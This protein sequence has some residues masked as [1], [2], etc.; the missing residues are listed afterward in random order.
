MSEPKHISQILLSIASDSSDSFGALLRQCPFIQAELIRR[1]VIK[2]QDLN[3]DQQDKLMD[4]VFTQEWMS[5]SEALT[6][7]RIGKNAIW[8][9]ASDGYIQFTKIDGKTFFRKQDLDKVI[10]STHHILEACRNSCL[11]TENNDNGD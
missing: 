5:E 8:R 7:L 6:Y 2:I 10:K 3:E 9:L 4:Y 11:K 1:G